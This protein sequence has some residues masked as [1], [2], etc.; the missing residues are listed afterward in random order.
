M[1]NELDKGMKDVSTK[2]KNPFGNPK[3][4]SDFAKKLQDELIER[5]DNF[6]ALE[7]QTQTLK[8]VRINPVLEEEVNVSSQYKSNNFGE[9]TSSSSI[10]CETPQIKVI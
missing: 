7:E 5:D 9:S 1:F 4:I 6:S 8:K 10:A 2:F 3:V